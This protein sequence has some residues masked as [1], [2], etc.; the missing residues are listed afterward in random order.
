MNTPYSYQIEHVQLLD[1]I[2]F[3]LAK[4][5]QMGL[6]LVFW[7]R[8][9]PVGH[10]FIRPD[11]PIN[12]NEVRRKSAS[13]IQTTLQ[14]YRRNQSLAPDGDSMA[15]QFADADSL[16]N[17]LATVLEAHQ[18][19][20]IP[21]A[22]PVTVIIC[23][24]NR[25]EDLHRCLLSLQDLRCQ[26]E[27]IIVVD[28]AP[29]DNRTEQVVRMFNRVRYCREPRPGL[30]VA[31][32]TGIRAARSPIIAYTDDDVAVHPLWV[33]Q[34]WQ[35]FANEPNVAAMTGL[36]I[37]SE[38]MTE[39]QLIF[40]THWSFNR[41]YVAKQYDAEYFQQTLASGPPVWEIG[42]GANMAFRRALFDEIGYFDERLDV[43][44]AG[45]SGDSELWYRTLSHG[46]VIQ[47]NPK[48][49]V[50]HTH[51]K[52]LAAVRKQVFNYMRGHTAA[53]LIQQQQTPQAGYSHYLFRVLPSY[54]VGLFREGFPAFR[55]RYRTLFA[56][57]Q[58]FVSGLLFYRKNR[59]RP[60]H[61]PV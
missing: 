19:E 15:T 59:L 34:V 42:A 50:F 14:A 41:G 44:A 29:S 38:L 18:P 7:Y 51:R 31:R 48:A 21:E 46:H 39:A 8:Q 5:S 4:K 26:P 33:Y 1:G 24:R 27:E 23:T 22:V 37:A 30:D 2:V 10:L 36:V 12:E 28:N 25:P 54:Y 60:P 49:V 6:Y 61:Y 35:T 47:Y 43:G 52:E 16:Q 53:A 13:A 56:E 3:P 32:N 58:G 17:I 20:A 55:F 57:V 45:C 40:E 9:I 11:E